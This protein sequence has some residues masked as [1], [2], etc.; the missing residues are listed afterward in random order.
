MSKTEKTPQRPFKKDDLVRIRIG[1][2]DYNLHRNKLGCVVG[3]MKGVSRPVVVMFAGIK[4]RY[5]PGDLE[6]I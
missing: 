3:V 5:Q 6:R 4:Y 1:C 2:R